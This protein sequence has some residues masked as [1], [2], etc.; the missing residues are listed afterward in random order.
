[1]AEYL[2]RT[3]RLPSVFRDVV[4]FSDRVHFPDGHLTRRIKEMIAT[5]VS[6]LNRCPY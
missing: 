2:A 6:A 1:M 3:V 5:Y 4:G